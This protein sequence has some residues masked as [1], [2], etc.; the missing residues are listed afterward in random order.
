MDWSYASL[1]FDANLGPSGDSPAKVRF[2]AP[3][4]PENAAVIVMNQTKR[5]GGGIFVMLHCDFALPFR[6]GCP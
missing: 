1:F 4:E 5:R 3:L 2:S 6:P